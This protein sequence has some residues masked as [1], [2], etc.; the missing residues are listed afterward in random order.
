MGEENITLKDGSQGKK[1]T[2]KVTR[3][4]PA[5]VVATP[6]IQYVYYRTVSKTAYGSTVDID[7]AKD[8]YHFKHA[9]G[10]DVYLTFGPEDMEKTFTIEEWGLDTSADIA[11]GMQSGNTDRYY[12]VELYKVVDTIGTCEGTLGNSV[13]EQRIL[14]PLSGSAAPGSDVFNRQFTYQLTDGSRTITDKGYD[15]NFSTTIK[16]MQQIVNDNVK[17]SAL[18]KAYMQKQLTGVGF[19]LAV[20]QRQ[21]DDGYAHIRLTLNGNT[22][23]EGK[24]DLSNK[25]VWEQ[26]WYPNSSGY[27]WVGLNDQIVVRTDASGKGSDNWFYG[28]SYVYAMMQDNRKPQQ[29]GVANLAF[30]KYKA[31][32]QISITVIYDEVIA[33]VSGVSL[34][35]VADIP[36]TNVQYVA[37]KG[38]NALTFT[39]TLSKDFEVTPDVNN[40]IKNLKPVTGT[41]K[42]VLGN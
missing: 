17:L 16:S 24:H 37:G 7:I 20:E 12:N 28:S 3:T 33:S 21:S 41:V 1:L 30:G 6:N 25:K 13:S 29:V 14:S 19:R 32:E 2:Y 26:Y 18:Q 11:A 35:Q 9:G 42:D 23:C 8:K 31:G 27:V 40:D 36:L 10:E 15:H 38:T 22:L 4:L 5:D 39:A 34:G